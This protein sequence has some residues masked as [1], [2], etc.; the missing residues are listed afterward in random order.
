MKNI[1]DYSINIVMYHYVRPIKKSK[2]PNIKG[3]E[4]ENFK[5][6]INFFSKKFNI[7]SHIDF[8]EIIKSKKIKKI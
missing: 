7:I 1:I 5:K 4:F 2:Y 3:L 6:Q 8:L